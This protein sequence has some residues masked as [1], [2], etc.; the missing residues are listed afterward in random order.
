MSGTRKRIFLATAGDDNALGIAILDLC[1]SSSG[2]ALAGQFIVRCA[3]AAALTGILLLG[4]NRKK[5]ESV[6]RVITIGCDQRFKTWEIG[7]I[8]D[9]SCDWCGVTTPQV[10]LVANQYSD[11]ADSGALV[12]IPEVRN[13]KNRYEATKILVAGVGMEVWDL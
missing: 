10:R 6:V 1:V 13:S 9:E 5:E 12:P 2:V 7:N 3:H 4:P 8:S 11:V